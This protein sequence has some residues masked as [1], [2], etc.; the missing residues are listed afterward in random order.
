[1]ALN[2]RK[3]SG[4]GSKQA[5]MEAGT[6]PARTVQM[7]DYGVQKQNDYQGQKKNPV[8]EVGITYE[9]LD[10]FMK[11]EDG[12]DKLDK[13]RWL[14]ERVPLHNLNSD[15]AKS[16]KRYYALDP[17]EEHAGDFSK[18]TDIPCMVTVVNNEK[19]GNVYTNIA[20]VSAMR[21]KDIKNAGPLVNPPKVF[22]LDDPDMTIFGSLP[23]W[24]QDK[25]KQNLDFG[26]SKLEALLK[27]APKKE[28]AKKEDKPVDEETDT[29]EDET[30]DEEEGSSW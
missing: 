5:P 28:K 25:I 1:M 6:Y 26:G 16:T 20:A 12:E 21:A 2:A 13:P 24:V 30:D 29:D 3:A 17:N 23:E 10:E 22:S 14:S 11:D 27:D 19:D 15:K 7:I 4:G 9:F 18:L 8:N